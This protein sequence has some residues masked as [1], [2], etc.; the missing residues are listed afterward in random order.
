MKWWIVATTLLSCWSWTQA[1][2]ADTTCSSALRTE[3]GPHGAS[4][5]FDGDLA[6][7]WVEG[8]SGSGVGEWVQI[9][10]R[11]PVMIHTVTVFGGDYSSARAFSE[12]NHLKAARLVL[13]S[14]SETR[15]VPL[16]FRDL[17]EP[18]TVTVDARVKRLRLVI[19]QIHAGSLHSDTAVAEIAFDLGSPD[20]DVL[21][22]LDRWRQGPEGR[23]ALDTARTALERARSRAEQGDPGSLEQLQDAVRLGVQP[24]RTYL[25]QRLPTGFLLAYVHPFPPAVEAL[26]ALRRLE[27]L[28]ALEQAVWIAPDPASADY[29]RRVSDYI[30]AWNQ[31]TAPR[32]TR[33]PAW[34]VHGV[35][36]GAL[37]GRGEPIALAAAPSGAVFVCDIG[38]NR[39]QRFNELGQVDRVAGGQPGISETFLGQD[40]G[41]HVV[42]AQP[43]TDPGSF[44]QPLAITAF[45]TREGIRVAVLDAARA[46]QV[47]DGDLKPLRR[48][49][50]PSHAPIERGIGIAGP[51]LMNR[52]DDIL[53]V[54]GREGFVYDL[55]GSLLHTFTLSSPA[56][57]AALFRDRIVIHPG[58]NVLRRYGRDGF[59]YGPFAALDST[60]FVEDIDIAAGPDGLL[61]VHTDLGVLLRFDRKGRARGRFTTLGKPM[62]NA[63]LAVGEDTLYVTWEDHVYRFP[64]PEK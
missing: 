24:V 34:G 7:A 35:E 31:F 15:E 42:G 58:G 20:S 21:E 18:V 6:T 55:E 25:E 29:Y 44:V 17:A 28:P 38:N 49:S 13:V 52:R 11:H 10:F 22:A 40:V 32:R 63:R 62:P 59:D 36:V 48:W 61:Y 19:D 37:A 46:L 45:E 5:A 9:A 53:C 50:V 43:G 47:L 60:A 33:L 23:K 57:T 51:S 2:L 64:L 30:R 12:Y 4:L 39:V 16:S 26:K 56:R 14:R 1:S 27:T 8:A 3:G 54:W 41:Y